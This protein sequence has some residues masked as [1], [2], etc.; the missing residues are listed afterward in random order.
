MRIERLD[1]DEWGTELP[2]SGFEVFHLPDALSVVRDHSDAECRLYAAKKGQETVGLFPVFLEDRRVGRM[3][4]SPPPGLSIP[5]LGPLLLPNSPK[6]RKREQINQALVEGVLDDTGADASTTLFRMLGPLDYTDPRPLSWSG[7]DLRPKFTY[8]V[9][10]GDASTLKELTKRFSKSLRRE[11]RRLPDLGVRIEDEG[12]TGAV[13]IQEDIADRYVEQDETPPVSRRF[14][15]DVVDALDDRY[16]AYV[17]RDESGSYLG[18]ILVLYSND[19]ASFWLGGVRNSYDGVSVNTLVHRRV[20]ED[21]LTDPELDSITGYDLVGANT[22]RLCE[23]K[24]KFCGDLE[25]YYLAES[26]GVGMKTAKTAYRMFSG[27]L[28]KS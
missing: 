27:G 12:R 11:M 21:V 1:F 23:Y 16:R 14:V 28:S 22:E 13:R 4:L 7:L 2:A 17:A 25:Q 9:D 3:A 18:G 5:R 26:S 24:A 8:V 19:L 10:V 6:R 20:L 15:E